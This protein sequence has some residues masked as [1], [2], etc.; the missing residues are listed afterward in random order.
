IDVRYGRNG[1]ILLVP[2]DVIQ[3]PKKDAD[4]GSEDGIVA[5]IGL[6]S[7]QPLKQER[8]GP[9]IIAVLDSAPSMFKRVRPVPGLQH[10]QEGILISSAQDFVLLPITVLGVFSP[11]IVG[12]IKIGVVV[13]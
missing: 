1:K 13:G 7:R 9:F 6:G 4:H 8:V 5:R 3:V 10:G 2:V 12:M 11:L